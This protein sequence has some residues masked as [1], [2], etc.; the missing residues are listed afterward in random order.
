MQQEEMGLLFI[1]HC[2]NFQRLS[3]EQLQAIKEEKDSQVADLT[4]QKQIIM[5][6]MI[7]LQAQF[8]II[9]CHPDIKEQVKELLN[10]INISENKGQEIIKER[11][12]EISKKMLANR[13]EM[14]IQQ[15]YEEHSFQ[16][17]GVLCNIEK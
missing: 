4:A 12:T 14:N 10:E 1:K 3:V 7:D 17:N 5:D 6:S 15:A 16:N 11:C 8:N 13:K 9:D 2:N